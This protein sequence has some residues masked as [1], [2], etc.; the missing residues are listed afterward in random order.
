MEN[1]SKSKFDASN[2]PAIIWFFGVLLW[3]IIYGFSLAFIMTSDI[4][5]MLK[6][7]YAVT[8]VGVIFC[9]ISGS[10]FAI[11]GIIPAFR[12]CFYKLPWLYPLIMMLTMHLSILT[13]AE[14]RLAKG[15]TVVNGPS[16]ELAILMM[17]VQI[18]LC[19]GAMCFYLNKNPMALRKY[20]NVEQGG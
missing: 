3:T 18:V 1:K 19:R 13:I 20:D 14:E 4:F 10:I 7:G 2:L 8:T 17:I 6:T 16:H 9:S 12:K 5:V 15:F 11:T